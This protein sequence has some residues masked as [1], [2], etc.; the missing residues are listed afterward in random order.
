LGFVDAKV[1]VSVALTRL[2][3]IEHGHRDR[4]PN[5]LAAAHREIAYVESISFKASD[6]RTVKEPIR[7]PHV[8]LHLQ[9]LSRLR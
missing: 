2:R 5:T 4:G 3:G 7:L 1:V 8:D 9:Q 6:L